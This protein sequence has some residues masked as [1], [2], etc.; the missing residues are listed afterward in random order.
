MRPAFAIA[1]TTFREIV[2]QPFYLILLVLTLLCVAT[3]P[4]I[5]L[6]SFTDGNKL[7]RDMGLASLLVSGLILTTHSA[8]LVMNAEHNLKAS[9]FILSKPV[10]RWIFIFSRHVGLLLALGMSSTVILLYTLLSVRIGVPE[11][12]SWNLDLHA[13]LAQALPLGLAIA[14]G[15][16][17]N[18]FLQRPFSASAAQLLFVLAV[19]GFAALAALDPKGPI[20]IETLKAG[21]LVCAACSILA[22]ASL[23][24]STRFGRSATFT[25]T[26]A[27]LMAGMVS[28]YVFGRHQAGSWVATGFY[29][30]LP[31]LHTFWLADLLL[32]GHPISWNYILQASVYAACFQLGLLFFAAASYEGRDV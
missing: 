29:H 16:F 32:L 15:A 18:Y 7:V 30:L 9:V 11:N 10:P 28:D 31:N 23:A 21:F 2:R 13:F 6:F 19:A 22:A 12:A 24:F 20:D 3:Y 14:A 1:A 25:F 27:L 17:L 26:L 8:G 5:A 4:Y